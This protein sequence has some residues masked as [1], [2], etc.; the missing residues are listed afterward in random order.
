MQEQLLKP[1]GATTAT[2]NYEQL[3][4][5]MP[6]PYERRNGEFVR[7]DLASRLEASAKF[8][9]PAG[10]LISTLEDV[11]RFLLLHRNHGMVE[12]NRLVAPE[13]LRELYKPQPATGRNGYGLGFNAP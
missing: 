9:N 7:V 12:G 6:T 10:R 11:G 2:F 1:I 8:P 4:A 3:K 13:V 5:R